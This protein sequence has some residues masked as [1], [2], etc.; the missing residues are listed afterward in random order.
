MTYF[1]ENFLYD[2]IKAV[3]GAG[4]V[5]ERAF[6][7]NV[8]YK[9]KDKGEIVTPIDEEVENFI[10][11]SL[12][13]YNF[14]FEGEELGLIEGSEKDYKIILDPIDGTTNFY[15]KIGFFNIA[16]ALEYKNEVI[17]GVV[18]NPLSKELYYGMKG[19]GAFLN[20]TPIK[21]EEFKELNK[22]ILGF[23]YGNDKEDLDLLIKNYAKIRKKVKEFRRF[24]S[25]NLE[26]VYSINKFH[27]FLGI[28]LKPYDF[29]ASLLIAKEAG[30]KIEKDIFNRG[31]EGDFIVLRKGINLSDLFFD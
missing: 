27:G 14:N 8:D 10:Y 5:I 20:F 6:S 24:G 2:A 18:Y 19:K 4:T 26:I 9:E 22:S 29:K 11:E 28:G 17:I 13:H 21:A 23:C 3:K 25:A 31:K 7:E 15:Y 30:L 1:L 12:K 16:L